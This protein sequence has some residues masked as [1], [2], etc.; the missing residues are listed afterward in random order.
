M[1]SSEFKKLIKPLVKECIQE[2][3]LE[4]GLLSNAIS[5]VVKGLNTQP[6]VENKSVKKQDTREEQNRLAQE[7]IDRRK[8]KINETRQKMMSAVGGDAYN[9]ADLFEGT[10]PMTQTSNPHSP[11]A[12]TAPS[13]AGVDISN[14]MGNKRVWNALLEG[15]K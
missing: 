11:L 13:D 4:E 14:L 8:A 12:N 15:K 7:E 2:A 6:L 5:E 9:G 10:T 1:K 3:L